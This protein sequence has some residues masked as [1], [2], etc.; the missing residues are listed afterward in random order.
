MSYGFKIINLNTA[1]PYLINDIIN[2]YLSIGDHETLKSMGLTQS[3]I[4]EL[5]SGTPFYDPTRLYG[6]SQTRDLITTGRINPPTDLD[7]P[8]DLYKITF[9]E[10]NDP[11][12]N[13]GRAMGRR[14]PDVFSARQ[15][16]SVTGI[17]GENTQLGG[18]YINPSLLKLE[19]APSWNRLMSLWNAYGG[20]RSFL[21]TA[22]TGHG[23]TLNPLN[24]LRDTSP[25]APELQNYPY[26]F[27][28]FNLNRPSDN[29]YF[30]AHRTA[31]SYND[32]YISGFNYSG[33]RGP[34]AEGRFPYN[35]Y[36][37]DPNTGTHYTSDEITND[38]AVDGKF[39]VPSY[40]NEFKGGRDYARRKYI[41]SFN[42][43]NNYCT[44]DVLSSLSNYSVLGHFCIIGNGYQTSE[45]G[46]GVQLPSGQIVDEPGFSGEHIPWLEWPQVWDGNIYRPFES[47]LGQLLLLG[48]QGPWI[49]FQKEASFHWIAM[50]EWFD[51]G[52]PCDWQDWGAYEDPTVKAA[53]LADEA[54]AT[55]AA[56]V[57]VP[58][59]TSSASPPLNPKFGDLWRDSTTGKTKV[60]TQ[61]S[62]TTGTWVDA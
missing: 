57:Y 45:T 32:G 52:C 31:A 33:H 44:R 41:H 21:M 16:R 17:P 36:E 5:E 55:S 58:T 56:S 30:N 34:W 25:K 20:Y 12:Y 3:I 24:Y 11:L 13:T 37:I 26:G 29:F 54:A 10:K 15:A 48:D 42:H 49:D 19:T 7:I 1:N 51:A 35:A 53:R 47:P 40:M 8:G 9:I 22:F 60:F 23:I 28:P 18:D 62:A 4:N 43:V 38:F 59:S 46:I 27:V 61:T 2:D 50:R 39:Q 14:G 6:L